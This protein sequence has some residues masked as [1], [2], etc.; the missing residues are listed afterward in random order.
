MKRNSLG[1]EFPM[2]L[3]FQSCL[4]HWKRQW[5]QLW[6]WSTLM[7]KRPLRRSDRGWKR[8]V[9]RGT[10]AWQDARSPVTCRRHWAET[11]VRPKPPELQH[12]A[13]GCVDQSPRMSI[14]WEKKNEGQLL[15]VY[16]KLKPEVTIETEVATAG[17][18]VGGWL[19]MEDVVM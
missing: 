4:D 18:L 15:E 17:S 7:S 9:H 14:T 11:W 8:N 5:D 16:N 10:K 12:Q 2:S 1:Y 3:K 6:G 13:P 19:S